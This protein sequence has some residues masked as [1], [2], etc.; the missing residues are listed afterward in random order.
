MSRRRKG[1]G[2]GHE[3][4]DERWLLTYSDM[5]TLLMTLFIVLWSISSV[6]VSKLQVLQQSLNN[7]FSGKPVTT[8]GQSVLAGSPSSIQGIQSSQAMEQAMNSAS[9]VPAELSNPISTASA[10]AQ[11][12]AAQRE[13]QS[14]ERVQHQVETYAQR[15]GFAS[16]IRT[17]IDERGL[18]IRLLTDK[19]LFD[20]GQATVKP[21]ALPLLSHIA[22]LVL[23]SGITNPIRIEG[24]TD[25]VPLSGGRFYDN[26]GLSAGRAVAVLE[27]FRRAG[28]PASRMS[29]AGYADTHPIAPNTT[30]AGRAQNR[31]VD[32]VV[33]RQNPLPQ[34]ATQ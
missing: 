30:A 16:E 29:V 24:N 3:G 4:A 9:V 22:G 23:R 15:H 1:G 5:I 21:G 31:R 18:V 8:G 13:Q 32:V 27:Q 25:N 34:G 20:S 2:G 6:N 10:Q 19:V 28:V 14:L 11:Q 12:Q 7:A 26:W 17:S 33:L